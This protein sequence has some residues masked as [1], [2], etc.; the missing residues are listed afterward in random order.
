MLRE[1]SKK[2]ATQV[3]GKSL[4]DSLRVVSCIGV[5]A[6]RDQGE[7]RTLQ[8]K[9]P[10]PPEPLI[11]W[12]KKAPLPRKQD[13]REHQVVNKRKPFS[14][15]GVNVLLSDVGL[16]CFSDNLAVQKE[17]K[18]GLATKIIK[19]THFSSSIKVIMFSPC[20]VCC[21]YFKIHNVEPRNSYWKVFLLLICFLQ[22][23]AKHFQEI[24]IFHTCVHFTTLT[25]YML[26]ISFIS[27][28]SGNVSS[29]APISSGKYV[30]RKIGFLQWNC[31]RCQIKPEDSRGV[32]VID[33]KLQSAILIHSHCIP[34]LRNNQTVWPTSLKWMKQLK[35]HC[36]MC[37]GQA[38]REI[39]AA[40]WS[41]NG[42]GT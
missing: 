5:W 17:R 29:L 27:V 21:Y 16:I 14:W 28:S 22:R 39:A 40:Y 26:Y 30:W 3:L 34:G 12:K 4:A 31:V 42:K 38:A 24:V 19:I 25:V 1:S 6:M 2:L 23:C 32:W 33:C 10:G 37:L 13:I 9:V 36:A 11:T 7:I 20:N 8:Q 15:R 18:S 41:K 35:A